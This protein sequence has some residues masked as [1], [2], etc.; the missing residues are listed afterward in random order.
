MTLH[1][2]LGDWKQRGLCSQLILVYT[3]QKEKKSK[4]KFLGK[5]NQDIVEGVIRV[6]LGNSSSVIQDFHTQGK[7][8]LYSALI[9]NDLLTLWSQVLRKERAGA[10]LKSEDLLHEFLCGLILWV[11]H[12][13]FWILMESWSSNL[14]VLTFLMYLLRVIKIDTF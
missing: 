6:S 7:P 14:W 1:I 2:P 10:H 4:L 13:L 12:L 3:I 9:C 11:Q 8:L 5:T